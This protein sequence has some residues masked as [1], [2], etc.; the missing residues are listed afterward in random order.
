MCVF[1]EEVGKLSQQGASKEEQERLIEEHNKEVQTLV[2]KMEADKLRMQSNLQ[3]RLKR[4]REEKLKN[5][6]AQIKEDLQEQKV[7]MAEKQK[8]AQERLNADEV[9]WTLWIQHDRK[10]SHR[11]FESH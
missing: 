1:Q 6:E 11:T 2:N 3:E 4:R 7:E 8:S 10:W 9:S 5:K